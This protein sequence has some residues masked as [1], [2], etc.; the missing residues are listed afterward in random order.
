MIIAD[1]LRTGHSM[2]E[3]EVF[4]LVARGSSRRFKVH[5]TILEAKGGNIKPQRLQ[6]FQEGSSKIYEFE[7]TTETIIMRFIEWAYKDDYTGGP[8]VSEVL[9]R[10][11]EENASRQP[12]DGRL[13]VV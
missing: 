1:S 9:D 11:W 13:L 10:Q 5:E 8:T 7:D 3:G 6:R 2:L 12:D 4:E